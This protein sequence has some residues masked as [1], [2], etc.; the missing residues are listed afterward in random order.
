MNEVAAISVRLPSH[1]YFDTGRTALE[2]D[3]DSEIFSNDNRHGTAYAYV[4][5]I[6]PEIRTIGLR[7][8][9]ACGE[10][11]PKWVARS[12]TDLQCAD[13]GYIDGNNARC[14]GVGDFELIE[15]IPKNGT[16]L[17]VQFVTAEPVTI[18]STCC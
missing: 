5:L 16:S 3:R 11:E 14:E 15:L 7:G 9:S 13:E 6:V 1:F 8:E 4:N 2:Q 17:S 18:G 12:S 10:P